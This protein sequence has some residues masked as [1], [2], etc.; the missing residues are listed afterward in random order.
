[1]ILKERLKSIRESF[2]FLPAVYNAIAL[3][4]ATATVLA[5]YQLTIESS[6]LG[7]APLSLERTTA[8]LTALA[9]A[10]LTMTTITFSAILVVLTTYS[11]QFSPRVLQDFIASRPTQHVLALFSSGFS[12]CVLAMLIV[13]E[14]ETY[15][16][17]A[18][19]ILG[20]LWSLTAIGAFIFL[21]HHTANWLRVSN[22]IA[23]IT[24]ETSQTIADVLQRDVN[25]T[26][27][28]VDDDHPLWSKPGAELTAPVAG[29]VILIEFDRLIEKA[30]ED[31]V[32][33]RLEISVGSFV[34]EGM[35]IL[36]LIGG[37]AETVDSD[38]YADLVRMNI[39]PKAWQD[40][41]F[42]IRKIAE[43]GL[44]A[45]SPSINDPYT[46]A[47]CI[48]HMA[49]LLVKL[50]CFSVVRNGI[51]DEGNKLRLLTREPGFEHYL[52]RAFQ[53]L[54]RYGAEDNT[55]LVAILNALGWIARMGDKRWHGLLWDFGA[56]TYRLACGSAE[57]LGAE[58]QRLKQSMVKLAD[59]VTRDRDLQ[60]LLEESSAGADLRSR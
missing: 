32:A 56:D 2:W 33:V 23:F 35:P 40:I 49:A 41:G 4:L 13:S 44:R 27:Q 22:L 39:E 50:S 55:T 53:E 24:A 59:A 1:M 16:L 31:D 36:T 28:A 5:D 37:N 29:Y 12:F 38:S 14:E 47:T 45:I 9:G 57:L 19:P 60:A 15:Q 48:H 8:I 20:V 46:A 42:G 43:I 7:V 52:L 6:L 51:A 26:R 58:H 11:S 25:E 18:T 17:L 54:R 30:V 3:I 34:L 10:I 21:L